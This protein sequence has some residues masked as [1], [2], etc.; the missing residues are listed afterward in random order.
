MIYY[1]YWIPHSPKIVGKKK[2]VDNNIYTFDIETSS[3][4]ILDGIQHNSLDYDSLTQD[5]RKRAIPRSNMYIWMLGIND[6]IYY[7]RTWEELEEFLL[8]ISRH[9]PEK[10]VM[11]I[12][13]LSFEFQYLYSYFK[14]SN[15]FA[16]KS[17][18]VMRCELEDFNFELRCTLFMSDARLEKLPEI[19]NLPVKKL[20][21]DLDYTKIRHSNTYLTDEELGY[22]EN[23][24]LVLY[25]YILFELETYLQVNKIPLTSTGHVRKELKETTKDNYKY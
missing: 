18:K 20:V 3:Y 9:I 21:G 6:T 16:R 22:C 8:N 2:K 4:F 13:N 15:V 19:Y 25:Y 12:H 1:K 5:E 23:D 24:C 11:F 10:K 7:G 17:H 14:I